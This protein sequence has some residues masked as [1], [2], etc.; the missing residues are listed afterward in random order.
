MHLKPEKITFNYA[1]FD[2]LKILELPYKG[3]KLSMLILLPKDNLEKIESSLTVDKLD[4]YKSQLKETKLDLIVL[5]KFETKTKYR[6]ESILANLGMPT[7]FNENLADFTGMYNKEKIQEN[8]FIN[9][10]IHQAYVKVNEEGTEA[11]A[12]TGVGMGITAVPP[13]YQFIVNRPF[14]FLIQEKDTGNILF[15]G[16]IVDPRE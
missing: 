2:D 8:L 4:E 1:E 12:A 6:L 3:N 13:R 14:I 10:V 16:K 15:L 5:P 9:F 11:A 7:A